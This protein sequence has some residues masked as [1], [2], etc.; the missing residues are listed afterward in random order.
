MS[1]QELIERRIECLQNV[2]GSRVRGTKNVEKETECRI[3]ALATIYLGSE[4][5]KDGTE[6]DKYYENAEE[7]HKSIIAN[8]QEIARVDYFGDVSGCQDVIKITGK[9]SAIHTEYFSIIFS[10]TLEDVC[11]P[12]VIDKEE[13]KIFPVRTYRTYNLTNIY[14]KFKEMGM[15]I[16]TDYITQNPTA[17]V[18]QKSQMK[19]KNNKFTKFMI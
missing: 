19:Q 7:A 11:F 3:E 15:D 9:V 18:L 13:G 8:F 10:P 12:R 6:V 2:I 1:E 4:H 5:Q 14:N 17:N 16:K